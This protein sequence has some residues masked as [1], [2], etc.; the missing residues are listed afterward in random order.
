MKRLALSLA[1]C[2]AVSLT[3]AAGALTETIAKDHKILGTDKFAGG[4]RTRFSFDGYEAWVV[5]PTAKA[6]EGRPWTWTM[7]WAGAYVP[8]TPVS[9]LLSRGW[10]H[11]TI[12][13]F[14][15]KMDETGLEVSR[16][17]QQYLVD[18][19]NFNAKARLIGMSWGGFFSVRYA[20]TY[21]QNVKSIYLDAPL[22]TF[23]KF[24]APSPWK[25]NPPKDGKWTEDPRM[26]LNRA[27][28]IANAKIPV[29]LL[30][31]GHDLIVNPKENCLEFIEKFKAA[32]GDL[33]VNARAAYGH[34]P[35]GVELDDWSIAK[36]FM[37]K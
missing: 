21:P 15:H 33:T 20:S 19:L 30:Y 29:L 8:R 16:R 3:A 24:S 1:T 2:I 10:H 9:K 26:P 32:G 11:V 23:G 28:M 36:F 6:A 14:D 31:G 34:H 13:T 7:Q 27:G 22:L 17:F 18:K 5:E 12:M 35:H 4:E 25:E 37:E